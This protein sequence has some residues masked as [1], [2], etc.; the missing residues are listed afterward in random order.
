[1]NFAIIG[2][3]GYVAARHFKAIQDTGNRL[4][5]AVDPHDAVGVLDRFSFETAYFSEIE[6][7]D[8][9]LWKLSNGPESERLHYVSICSPN[10]LHDAHMR[11]AL[12]LGANVICEK[13]LVINPW[14]LDPLQNLERETGK[15]INSVLQLRV[16]P[17][18]IKLKNTLSPGITKSNVV[19][20]YVTAR[21]P[22]YLYSW[23]GSPEKSGGIAT[24]IGIHL[25]DLLI[26]LFGEVLQVQV[27]L[28]QPDRMSGFIE[29]QR[30]CVRWFLSINRNDLPFDLK[31][32]E[33]TT[34]RSIKIDDKELEFTDGFSGLHTE[35]Y[36]NAL[37]GKGIGIAD[38]RP[39]I[40]LVHRIRTSKTVGTPDP[41]CLHPM[42]RP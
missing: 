33:K 37:A 36:R 34:H 13:P 17:E 9:H 26:W 31:L 28:N 8:R 21:G 20:T 3:A 22:W 23:K 29:L 27:H 18:L 2:A 35:L 41:T 25:F 40:E 12:R 16:H 32:G 6:R 7:F 5:A 10:Y 24:N 38:A 4:I 39:A 42:M 14:N 11:M 19:L 30:A 1:M 15:R